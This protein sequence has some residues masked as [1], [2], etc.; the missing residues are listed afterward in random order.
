MSTWYKVPFQ[1][2]VP[3]TFSLQFPNGT[4]Y[5]MRVTFLFGDN[6]SWLLDISD[7]NGNQLCCGIPLVTGADL[8]EQFAYLNFGCQMFALTDGDPLTPP[9]WNNLGTL[10]NLFLVTNP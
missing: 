4:Q 10:G 1:N 6:P 8:L 7:A 2:S 5:Q 3:Q 9:T